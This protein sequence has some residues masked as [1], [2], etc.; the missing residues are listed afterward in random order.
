MLIAALIVIGVL[1]VLASVFSISDNIIQIEAQKQGIDTRKK[2]M[3]IFP[4]FSELFGTPAPEYADKSTFHRLSKGFD[5]KL[6]GTAEGDVLNAEVSRYAV[7][8]TDFRGIAPIPKLEVQEGQEVSAGEA[9]FFDKSDPEIKYV[10]PVSGEVVEVRRGTKRSISH[11][12]ILADKEQRQKKNAVPSSDASREEWIAYL[13][14]SGAWPH[15]NQRP[16]DVI[17][18]PATVPDNIFISGFDSA[19]LAI[20]YDHIL[21]LRG[22]DFQ[23][24]ID[25]LNRLTEGKVFL[26]LDGRSGKRPHEVL[27]NANNVETHWFEGKHPSGNVG[28]Q[29]HHIAPIRGNASVWTLKIED[30]LVIGKLCTEGVYDTT[31]VVGITGARCKEPSL[32]RTLAGANLSDLLKDNLVSEDNNRVILG[33][34]LTG[35]QAKGDEFLSIRSN[36]ITVLKE[37]NYYELFGWLLPI[38]PRPSTSK[39]YPNFLF[40]DHK[41]DGDTNTHGEQRA[42]VV[43]GQYEK[44]LPMDIYPQH[45]MKAILTGDIERMEALGINE[46]SEEDVALAEFS[47][48]SKQPLQAILRDGLNMMRE[49]A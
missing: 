14:G 27:L 8:P 49:Q 39:T 12:V 43:T 5:I 46:L 22:D 45:L 29:I 25:V 42:F 30:V 4:S 41:F 2:N 21:D 32:I 7:K 40:S 33:N 6:A 9:L 38:K 18:D 17:A 28:V 11:V 36:Q 16:F 44:V 34:V 31:R 37:G 19:P 3:S 10:A 20:S 15:I 26:G 1:L 23:A 13:K 47:C 35:D 48:T 24:G